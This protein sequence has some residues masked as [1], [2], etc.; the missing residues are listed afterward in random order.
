MK[1]YIVAIL[2]VIGFMFSYFF[3]NIPI[4]A[5]ETTFS[6]KARL[7][8]K[9]WD[10][11]KTYFDLRVKPGEVENLEVEVQNYTDQEIT[12]AVQTN[13]AVTTDDGV[14][15][16]ETTD[17]K[18]DETMSH[19]F[20]EMVEVDS[21]VT[22]APNETKK[23]VAKVT[24]PKESFEGIILGGFQ[25]THQKEL[26]KTDNKNKA[27]QTQ[28]I[29]VQLSENDD[30]VKSEV[31]LMSVKAG[32]LNGSNMILATLQNP[33]PK[34]L[35]NMVVT[36][37]VFKGTG[38]RKSIYHNRK[39]NLN[40]APNSTFDYG[41]STENQPF[42]AG[43]YTMK[44]L[45]EADGEQWELEEVFEIKT[46]EAKNF[47]AKMDKVARTNH[48]FI[49]ITI[50]IFLLVFII[51]GLLI[52]VMRQK[53][54]QAKRK[55]PRKKTKRPTQRTKKLVNPRKGNPAKKKMNSREK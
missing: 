22:L 3:G 21:E 27:I 41:I 38:T 42:K 2:T 33:A 47:N 43:K 9:Q 48:S 28:V 25:F 37:D 12:V 7:P 53:Q 20:S 45:V 29:G 50:G 32:Q 10:Q 34:I 1:R 23:V 51:G 6:V 49:Y 55:Q 14:I 30:P 26:K 8:E 15:N 44:L 4:C 46:D 54:Q 24:V 18:L 13:N 16:Y 39:E 52:W 17:P 35:S 5:A 40:M 19:P 36:A 31:N 11:K